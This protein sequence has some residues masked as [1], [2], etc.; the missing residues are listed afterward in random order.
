MTTVDGQPL[1]KKDQRINI[2]G[3]PVSFK[4]DHREFF[5]SICDS[6]HL[7]DDFFP[8]TAELEAGIR[9]EESEEAAFT[10][11]WACCMATPKRW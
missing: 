1:L 4:I 9:R 10:Q 8:L 11:N 3:A 6:E 2:S 5:L 7:P